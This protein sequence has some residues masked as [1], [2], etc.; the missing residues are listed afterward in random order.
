M[1]KFTI[2]INYGNE[3]K[4]ESENKISLNFRFSCTLFVRGWLQSL[5]GAD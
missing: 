1:D 3:P 2:E 5:F 4:S